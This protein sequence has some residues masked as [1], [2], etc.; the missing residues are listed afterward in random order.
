[1]KSEIFKMTAGAAATFLDRATATPNPVEAEGWMRCAVQAAGLASSVAH[2][3]NLYPPGAST[4]LS[5]DA[6]AKNP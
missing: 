2:L 5:H 4:P 1:M 3:A 6:E